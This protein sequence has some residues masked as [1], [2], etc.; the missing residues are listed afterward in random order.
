[1]SP[2]NADC[3]ESP[4]STNSEL[5][6]TVVAS[7]QNGMTICRVAAPVIRGVTWLMNKPHDDDRQHAG[8]VDRVGQQ[9]RRERGHEHGDA[10]EHRVIHPATHLPADQ[11]DQ[12]AAQHAAAVR[13]DQQP[14]DVPAGQVLLA[15]GHAD[16]QSVEHECGAVVDQALGAQHGHRAPRQVAGQDAD[17]GRVGRG[18]GGAEHPGRPP[19]QAESVR[20][21]RDRRGGG[22]DEDR[23]REDD[24][25]QVVADLA[26]RGGQALPVEQ[27]RQE[28]QEHDL[29]RQLRVTQVRRE[30]HQHADQHQQDR[31]SDRVA[32]RERA[33]HDQG[34]PEQTTI[35]SPSTGPSWTE[36]AST[37][38]QHGPAAVDHDVRPADPRRLVGGQEDAPR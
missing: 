18:E 35:S 21:H 6:S 19:L 13:Q 8:R 26:Q 33:T 22:D 30:P 11:A 3:A 27:R 12:T 25:P 10:L 2:R 38:A 24:D 4:I 7:A 31:R 36:I 5:L 37:S 15:D 34:D 29:R 20:H 1:M 32:A 16:R 28:E 23:A 17:G 9:E 14:G